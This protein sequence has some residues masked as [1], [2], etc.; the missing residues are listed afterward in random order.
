VKNLGIAVVLG[1]TLFGCMPKSPVDRASVSCRVDRVDQGLEVLEA[2]LTFTEQG[3]AIKGTIRNNSPRI[4]SY[5]EVDVTLIDP[6]GRPIAPTCARIKDFKPGA[7]W[8]WT[9]PVACDN[10]ADFEIVRVLAE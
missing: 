8:Y 1:V 10:I 4:C 2:T 6:A 7:I 3:P 9:L 5:A